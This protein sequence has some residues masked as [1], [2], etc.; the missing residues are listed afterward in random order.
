MNIAIVCTALLGLLLF[1]LGSTCRC[2]VG[3][4]AQ[5]RP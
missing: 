2:S 3:K 1:G 5:H 4:P